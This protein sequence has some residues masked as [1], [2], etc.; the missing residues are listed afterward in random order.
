[1]HLI[2]RLLI[3]LR[4]EEPNVSLKQRAILK[5]A[6]SLLDQIDNPVWQR[7]ESSFSIRLTEEEYLALP[8]K[9]EFTKG[10]PMLN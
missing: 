3:V 1:M 7:P 2:D 9:I 10:Q 5:M 8:G 4:E 6:I